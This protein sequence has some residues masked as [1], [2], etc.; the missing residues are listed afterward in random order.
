LGAILTRCFAALSHRLAAQF[1]LGGGKEEL[2]SLLLNCALE[3]AL[4]HESLVFSIS[5]SFNFNCSSD[6][7]RHKYPTS[8]IKH[9][10]Y[11]HDW[12]GHGL[13]TLNFGTASKSRHCGF[14][15]LN[16]EKQLVDVSIP[17]VRFDPLVLHPRADCQ[18]GLSHKEDGPP[19]RNFLKLKV[20]VVE[21]NRRSTNQSL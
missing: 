1:A 8:R 17:F 2:S 7:K 11:A 18:V 16:A 12:D 19:F 15:H 6:L 10:L 20:H 13:C 14:W 21:K 4:E 3:R 9:F 5:L